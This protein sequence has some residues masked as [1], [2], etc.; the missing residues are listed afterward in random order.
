[1]RS[2]HASDGAPAFVRGRATRHATNG[3]SPLV[4]EY[5]TTPIL[6]NRAIAMILAHAVLRLQQRQNHLDNLTEQ[7]VHEAV[8][9]PKG[10]TA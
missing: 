4:A 9:N 3:P 7:R 1:M 2:S 10:E 6:P 5:G 8:L